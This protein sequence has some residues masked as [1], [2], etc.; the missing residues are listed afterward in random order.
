MWITEAVEKLPRHHQRERDLLR[1]HLDAIQHEGKVLLKRAQQLES[2]L[3]VKPKLDQ[4]QKR[5]RR[6]PRSV[7]LA[8]EALVLVG[9][10]VGNL[11]YSSYLDTRIQELKAR[12]DGILHYI[13]VS[14]S[15]AGDN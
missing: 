11:M 12:Q 2:M 15:L 8:V 14:A 9:A 6:K 3:I 1:Q 7:L 4:M 13:D 10:S 5:S